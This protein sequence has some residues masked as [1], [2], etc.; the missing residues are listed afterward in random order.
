[1]IRFI[2]RI[3][4]LADLLRLQLR[5]LICF[6]VWLLRVASQKAP[7]KKNTAKTGG[8]EV[9]GARDSI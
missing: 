6:R 7:A 9:T 2:A 5:R 3:A 4:L 8:F 1:M